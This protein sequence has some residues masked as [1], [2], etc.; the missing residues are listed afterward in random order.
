M[1]FPQLWTFLQQNSKILKKI[2]KRELYADGG[3]TALLRLRTSS[4]G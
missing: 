4:L 2:L 3:I 1:I